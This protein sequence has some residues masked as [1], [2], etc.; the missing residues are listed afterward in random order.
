MQRR[1]VL[2]AAAAAAVATLGGCAALNTVT[3][4]VATYGDWPA[5]RSPGRYAFERRL[6]RTRWR[7]R[8]SRWPPMPARLT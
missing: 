6:A 1:S 5:G 2:T 4:E 3:S 8:A 7:L